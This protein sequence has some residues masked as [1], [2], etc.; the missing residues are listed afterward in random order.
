LP[1]TV[2]AGESIERL[3]PRLVG[4]AYRMLGSAT[5]AEDIVQDVALR[6][7]GVNPEE[8]RAPEQYLTAM[9]A[10]ACIDHLR[11]ARRRREVYVGPW[12][13]EPVRG[14][15]FDPGE[16]IERAETVSTAFLV[17]LQA[18]SPLERAAFLLRSVF[19]YDYGE[20]AATL[21]RSEAACR[22]LV[23][24]AQAHVKQRRQRFSASAAAN[25]RL[26]ERFLDAARSGDVASLVRML[27]DDATMWADGGGKVAAAARP[28]HG[29]E[30]VARY[31][32]G[33]LEKM[34]S[35]LDARIEDVNGAPG[36]VLYRR[37]RPDSAISLAMRGRR[38]A[39]V[40]NQRNP[41]KLRRL[42]E[43]R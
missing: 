27:A 13:P 39:A 41:E 10:R 35:P 32:I 20:I 11:S 42:A 1:G 21:G 5:E 31:L 8:V 23:S 28:V 24:R 26:T 4:L 30:R 40:F 43:A 37:G 29:A 14:G 19:E 6:F 3:R 16:G 36:I 9:T 17:L 33:V 38:V 25:R 12:L 18:L 34:P 15:S 22:Q 7:L 2:S